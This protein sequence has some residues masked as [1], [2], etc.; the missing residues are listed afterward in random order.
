LLVLGGPGTGK[1][2]LAVERARLLAQQ[3]G[4]VLL[5]CYNDL[6]SRAIAAQLHDVTH[7]EVTT[8][9]RFCMS[10]LRAAEM[11]IPGTPS[12]LWWETQA[13]D[14]LKHTLSSGNSKFDA[15]IV[16]EAQDFAP[17]WFDALMAG[18]ND[19]EHGQVYVFADDHQELWSR[20]WRAGLAHFGEFE[21]LENCRNSAPIAKCVN[22]IYGD[23]PPFT[24]ASGAPVVTLTYEP[25]EDLV[26]LVVELG[27]HIL[28]EQKIQASDLTILVDDTGLAERLRNTYIGS[29][30]IVSFGKI[31]VVCETI[32]RF[33]GLESSAALLILTGRG[34]S[35]ASQIA[36]AYIGLSRARAVAIVLMPAAHPAASAIICA[37]GRK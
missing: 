5:V 31:G 7:V 21:L 28:H 12:A 11:S 10:R 35:I 17:R 13:A 29:T 2:L 33:K 30:P 1:T 34:S 20:N 23:D 16:D 22:A 4:R 14:A 37:A 18:L 27:E 8:F 36:T 25:S 19:R 6:L 26:A 32:G 24:G 15:L 3:S 9:H